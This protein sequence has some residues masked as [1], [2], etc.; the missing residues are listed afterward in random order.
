MN[1]SVVLLMSLLFAISAPNGMAQVPDW[2]KS[3]NE[4]LAA[5]KKEGK[6]VVTGPPDAQVRQALPAAFK[7]RYGITLEYLGGRSS[8]VAGRMRSERSAG[9]YSVDAMVGGLNTMATILHREQLIDPIKPVLMLPEVL[10][11]SKWTNGK[12]WFM[13]PEQQYVLRVANHVT[14]L[15]HINT[16][17]IKPEQLRSSR[18]LLDPK[19]RGKI[20]VM[21]PTIPGSGTNTA[22]LLHAQLGPDFVK[23]LYIDQKPMLTRDTRQLTDALM[24]GTYPIVFGA[25]DEPIEKMRREGMP[26]QAVYGFS[27]VRPGVTA[28]FGLV[29]MVNKAPHPNA[30]KVFIN[31]L[32]S[33]EGQEVY[34]RAL[35]VAPARNDIDAK[36][37]L[38][39]EMIPRAGVDYFDRFDWEFVLT[40][41]EKVRLSMKELMKR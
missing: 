12:L 32:A 1:V 35:G 36:S 33:K 34:A 27:D 21:D 40:T 11:T 5:A 17:G 15:M 30:A 25:E 31:W 24:R 16:D 38:Q 26:L 7:A 29:A 19:W 4:T 41:T 20:A 22:A 6:V 2:Q 3:W 18:D 8:E 37:Y 23:Q 28:G 39:P 9:V 13:D 14:P 10:D